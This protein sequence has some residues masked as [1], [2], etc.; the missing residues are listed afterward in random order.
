VELTV[1]E[2]CSTEQ[3]VIAELAERLAQKS[4][5]KC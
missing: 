1:C 3:V 4:E 5:Q 2:T